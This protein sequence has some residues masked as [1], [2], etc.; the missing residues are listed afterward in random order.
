MEAGRNGGKDEERMK[1]GTAE[2]MNGGMRKGERDEGRK[3]NGGMEE[4]RDGGLFLQ[5][6]ANASARA[7]AAKASARAFANAL[8]RALAK[9]L[10][11]EDLAS[12][13]GLSQGL[14]LN[15]GQGFEG[16]WKPW[17]RSIASRA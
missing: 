14:S 2:W 11:R 6:L 16:P 7:L 1:G 17:K 13:H 9:A 12:G 8:V 3:R 4:G 15:L 10:G 5:A